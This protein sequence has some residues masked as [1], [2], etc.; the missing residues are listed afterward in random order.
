MS[1]AD[2]SHTLKQASLTRLAKL[3]LRLGTTAFGGPAA[4]IAIS[5]FR[6]TL[7]TTPTLYFR[8]SSERLATPQPVTFVF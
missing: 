7:G 8:A 1:N 6:K 5:M 2:S 3:F 4:H